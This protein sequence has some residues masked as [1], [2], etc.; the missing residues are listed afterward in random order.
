MWLLCDAQLLG[1]E[2]KSH[3]GLLRGWGM[4]W[5]E[6]HW[7]RG[8]GLCEIGEDEL[9]ALLTLGVGCEVRSHLQGMGMEA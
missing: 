4:A 9:L 6:C 2:G 5:P 1:R 8:V 7:K 3:A